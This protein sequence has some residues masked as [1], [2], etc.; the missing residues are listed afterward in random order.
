[1]KL[2]TILLPIAVLA[3]PKTPKKQP[4][5]RLPQNAEGN[6]DGVSEQC[7]IQQVKSDEYTNGILKYQ[8][9]ILAFAEEI[10]NSDCREVN[11]EKVYWLRIIGTRV[12]SDQNGPYVVRGCPT[13]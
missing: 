10:E 13:V 3:S 8:D 4:Q 12:L 7:R 11:E 1:M 5:R 6:Q 9:E 2:S